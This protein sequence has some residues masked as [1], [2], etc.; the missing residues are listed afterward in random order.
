MSLGTFFR[1]YVYIPLG[2]NRKY[3]LRNI[4]IVWA[5]T[6]LWHGASWNFVIW[7][8]YY[9]VF[10]VF[11]KYVLV[12]LKHKP[13]APVMHIYTLLAV[14]FGW[15]FFYYTN[16]MDG[17]ALFGKLFGGGSL[18]TPEVTLTLQNNMFF[19]IIALVACLPATRLLRKWEERISARSK[20]AKSAVFVLKYALVLT[21]L[22]LSTI[23][24]VGNSFNPFIY[25]RF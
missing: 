25:Y 2:G 23:Q 3:Q 20:R 19:L 7:G 24:L 9:F 8:L 16:I 11:E 4:F 10:L 22:L 1:D 18:T 21:L 13:P 12:R 17:F 5:L 15:V 6:G 14:I